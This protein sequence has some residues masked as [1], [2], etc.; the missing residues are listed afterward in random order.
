MLVKNF[1]VTRHGRV[2]FYDYDELGTLSEFNFR[3]LPKPRDEFEMMSA[4]A[5]FY[6]A[7]G[8][9]FPEEI[10]KFLGLTKDLNEVFH[11]HHGDLLAP[12]F[13]RRMQAKQRDQVLVDI[14]PYRQCKR[15]PSE[16]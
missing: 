14:F 13:W 6:V 8:D 1:G 5:W 7:P 4:D 11:E 12:A 15:F 3:K 2:I 16:G 10:G 9:V